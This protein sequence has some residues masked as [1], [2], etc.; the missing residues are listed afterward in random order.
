MSRTVNDALYSVWRA[1][2]T[3]C[4]D[5]SYHSYHRYGGRGIKVCSEWHS[6]QIFKRDMGTTYIVGVTL[7]RIDNDADYSLLNCR[8]LPKGENV[9]TL[10][11]DP[12]KLL[13]L[14]ESGK[15]KQQDL[16]D[17]L[18]TDQPH[19]SRILARGRKARAKSC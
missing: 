19:V 13:E 17:M 8:W 7:D 16:A 15:Y 2:H 10:L 18:G 9:K 14:Y 4:Y 5:N 12:E 1:M 6:Y 3:R 11:V